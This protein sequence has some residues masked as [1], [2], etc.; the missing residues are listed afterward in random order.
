MTGPFSTI[1]HLILASASPRRQRF[2]AEQGLNFRVQV[3]DVDESVLPGETPENFVK[4]LAEEKAMPVSL[5]NPDSWILSADTAVVV[6]QAILGKPA[7]P[8]NAVE[9]LLS[10]SGRWHQVWTGFCLACNAREIC[11]VRVVCTDVCFV[12]KNR[13]L[14]EA[15]VATGEP[16][17]KAGAYGIQG[18]G[19]VFVKEIRGSY[20]NVVGLPLAEVFTELLAHGVITPLKRETK[21]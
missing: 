6:D 8:A 10:L 15:Y 16:L 7:D 12:A 20:S 13:E 5:E 18:K 11:A 17:D 2:L 3:A 14:C 9:M 1:A 21:K 4:R 19:G